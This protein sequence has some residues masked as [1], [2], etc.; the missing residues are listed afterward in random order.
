MGIITISPQG[1]FQ[2]GGKNIGLVY[3]QGIFSIYYTNSVFRK[4]NG[5][6]H[7]SGTINGKTNCDGGNGRCHLTILK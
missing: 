2:I 1:F 3:N 7:S 5:K 4:E 6:F